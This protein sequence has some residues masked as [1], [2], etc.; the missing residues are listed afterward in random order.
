M[1]YGTTLVPALL[2]STY[3]NVSFVHI[4]YAAQLLLIRWSTKIK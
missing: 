3:V 2:L 1:E 4:Y